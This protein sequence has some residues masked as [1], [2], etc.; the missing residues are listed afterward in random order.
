MQSLEILHFSSDFFNE[1]K[2]NQ[3]SLGSPDS[4][5]RAD[6]KQK[7]EV[8]LGDATGE[9]PPA[10]GARARDRVASLASKIV[11][12]RTISVVIFRRHSAGWL[13]L[14]VMHGFASDR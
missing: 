4:K 6:R 10:S 1:L 14:T 3:C 8:A 12:S 2:Q 11:C 7:K 5:T 9:E 13:F